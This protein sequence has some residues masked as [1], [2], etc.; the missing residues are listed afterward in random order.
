MDD[1]KCVCHDFY[2]FCFGSFDLGFLSTART[3]QVNVASIVYV[4]QKRFHFVRAGA[5][6]YQ[7]SCELHIVILA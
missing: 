3:G 4:S 1:L 6:S 7:L 2:Q 5:W